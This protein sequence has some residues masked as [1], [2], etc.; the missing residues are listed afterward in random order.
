MDSLQE[1]TIALLNGTIGDRLQPPLPPNGGSK[2]TQDQLRDVCCHLTNMIEDIVDKA[3][4]S[5][6][7]CC[8]LPNY[9]T[10]CRTITQYYW[11]E[12]DHALIWLSNYYKHTELYSGDAKGGV[13]QLLLITVVIICHASLVLGWQ[14]VRLTQ[15]STL[16]GMYN[17]YQPLSW[18]NV[19]NGDDGCSRWQPIGGL[20][21]QVGWFGLWLGGCLALSLYS[22]HEP[23]ELTVTHLQPSS[24][25]TIKHNKKQVHIKAVITITIAQWII[26]IKKNS[27]WFKLYG[28]WDMGKG[29]VFKNEAWT[30]RSV[31]RRKKVMETGIWFANNN[32]TL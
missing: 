3:A 28:L 7:G 8:L 19:I 15:P 27:R 2:C 30:D 24:W 23:S 16:C 21:A 20:T 22:S 9:S 31:V 4:V 18:V 12:I 5:C 13:A 32:S 10:Q 25:I 11:G 17:E 26:T 29:E 1:T 6:A 14:P